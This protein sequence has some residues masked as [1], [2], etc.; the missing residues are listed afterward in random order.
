MDS[1][2]RCSTGY[3]EVSSY[4]A[5]VL[6]SDAM[7]KAANVTVCSVQKP[8]GG[9][10]SLCVF[11]P[12]ADCQAAIAAGVAVAQHQGAL[13]EQCVIGR[14]DNDTLDLWNVHIQTMRQRKRAKLCAP[15]PCPS[16]DGNSGG[17]VVSEATPA[18]TTRKRSPKGEDQ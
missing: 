11:G 7:C 6:T 17:L 15:D 18:R 5:A 12:L 16:A 9:R 4:V 13:L 3:I 1:M 10:V 2:I 8:G 14:P